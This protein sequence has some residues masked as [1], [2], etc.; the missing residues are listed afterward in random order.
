[1]SF[2]PASHESVPQLSLR[3]SL[4]SLQRKTG[5]HSRRRLR[6]LNSSTNSPWVAMIWAAV[7]GN[8]STVRRTSG[9][10]AACMSG[11]LMLRGNASTRN[12]LYRQSQSTNT[13]YGVNCVLVPHHEV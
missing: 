12:S 1:M 7:W 8:R 3:S 6:P 2:E 10:R 5:S 4:A 9:A 13:K 11:S